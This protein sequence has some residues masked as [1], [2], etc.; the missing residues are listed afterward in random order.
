MN[1]SRFIACGMYA[2]NDDIKNAWQA[3]FDQF[4]ALVGPISGLQQRL[5]FGTDE[6]LL[7]DPGLLIG[8]TCGYPLMTGLQDAVMPFCAP[9]FEV[10][11]AIGKLYSSLFIVPADSSLESLQQCC[12]GIV[13]INDANSNSGMNV[14]RYALA[15][16]KAGPG[17]FSDVLMTG[18]H[19]ASLEAVAANR[20]QLAAI[21]CVS[22]QLL[23]ARNPGLD[24]AIRVI[25]FSEP[26][27]GL[28]LVVA[29]A[30]YSRQQCNSY[31]EALNQALRQTADEVKQTLYLDRFESAEL[32]DYRSI[33]ALENYAV[34]A[35]YATLN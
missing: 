3:L 16:L 2:P 29:R 8:H 6:S 5:V 25:G 34:E 28:P 21:D 11:G 4:Y 1:A 20:A 31:L 10:P 15:K 17:Y 26:T 9:C 18:G 22:Y 19:L 33:L 23:T 30:Q 27:C 24:H 7:R 13:A 12:G 32:D 14:L 35:G